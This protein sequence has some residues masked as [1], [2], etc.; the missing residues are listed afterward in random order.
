MKVN[1]DLYILPISV[2]VGEWKS[3]LNLSL[4]VDPV[5]GAVLVDTAIPGKEDAIDA[6][7]AEIG[8][9]LKDVKHVIVTHQDIDHIGSLPAVKEATRADVYAHSVEV[10]Y[11]EG[12]TKMVKQP[13][14]E[15]LAQNPARKALFD[16]LAF[17]TVEHAVEDGQVLDFAGGVRVIFTPGHT[18]GHISLFLERSKTLI[19]GD[20]M[21]SADGKLAGLNEPATPDLPTAYA[22]IRKLAEELPKVNAIVCY[23][24]GLVTEDAA[25]QLQR[26]STANALQ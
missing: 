2:E 14:P 6:A 9:S 17:T 5:H 23:H 15:S 4:I 1:D 24:G 3:V 26:V 12:R 10:P 13:T 19:T 25:G 8:L 22:S 11:I 16:Q 20:A 7:L 18:P 21:I